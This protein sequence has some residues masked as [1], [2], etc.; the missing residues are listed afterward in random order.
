MLKP[1]GTDGTAHILYNSFQFNWVLLNR[2]TLYFI[3]TLVLNR[4]SYISNLDDPFV[5]FA[6]R[7]LFP[8]C[9]API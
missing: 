3:Q 8:P 4:I 7:A 5:G 9:L 1:L 2:A 6:L